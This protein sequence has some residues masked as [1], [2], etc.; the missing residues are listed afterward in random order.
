MANELFKFENVKFMEIV[1]VPD[2]VIEPDRVT[3][4]MGPSGSGKTTLLRL[5]N[6]MISP[7]EG[8]ILYLGEDLA[9]LDS[10]EHRRQV[11]MLSQEPIMFD[12]NIRDN[13]VH[14]LVVQKRELPGDEQ[15]S[16][17]LERVHL[18]KALDGD[19][20]R[21]SGGERQRLALARVLLLDSKV[22]LLD[23]PSSSLDEKTAE[24]V[25]AMTTRY[26]REQGKTLVM[27]THSKAIADRYSD[28]V[29]EVSGGTFNGRGV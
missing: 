2:L 5:L 21:L 19:V 15:L 28:I 16:D 9:G 13:L 4:L 17:I 27:V 11:T 6:K 18:F 24:A 22:Y 20:R 23:E 26:V 1:N 10:V 25:I 3:T 14:G 7:T 29:I 8:R 12:G